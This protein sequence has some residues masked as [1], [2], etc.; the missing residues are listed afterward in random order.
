LPALNIYLNFTQ[1]LSRKKLLC[2]GIFLQ[3]K[4]REK[5]KAQASVVLVSLEKS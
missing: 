5:N 1:H 2:L 3:R 4:I